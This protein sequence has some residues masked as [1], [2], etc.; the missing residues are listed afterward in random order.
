MIEVILMFMI[1]G[2]DINIESYKGMES[3]LAFKSYIETLQEESG[4][5]SYDQI[6]CIAINLQK[7]P[8]KVVEGN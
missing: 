2:S 5:I 1:D 8:L 3:C 6:E 7:Q 4:I